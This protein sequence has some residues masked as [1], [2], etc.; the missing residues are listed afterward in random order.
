MIIRKPYI[1][2]EFLSGSQ[3]QQMVGRAGRAGL[4]SVGESVTLLQP[5]DRVAFARM[6]T[7]IPRTTTVNQPSAER[8]ACLC[9]SS[10]LF[11]DGKGLR[12]LLLS[13]IGLHVSNF[14]CFIYIR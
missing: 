2:L 4:D 14:G 13:L 6:L 1:G 10:L 8:G 12:Q 11:R 9:L 5:S 7:A 3:Y